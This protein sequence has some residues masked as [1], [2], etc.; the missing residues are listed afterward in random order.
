MGRAYVETGGGVFKD[1]ADRS[2]VVDVERFDHGMPE[3]DQYG[4]REAPLVGKL[5][6]CLSQSGWKG[7]PR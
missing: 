3:F 2:G 4:Q 5:R 1:L 7:R 6:P